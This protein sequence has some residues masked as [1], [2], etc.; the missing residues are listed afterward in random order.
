[1]RVHDGS[2]ALRPLAPPLLN[3]DL[4]KNLSDPLEPRPFRPY[5]DD[6]DPLGL[7]VGSH[8]VRTTV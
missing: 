8:E 1:M 2:Q 4:S 7:A 5:V 6:L 3:W